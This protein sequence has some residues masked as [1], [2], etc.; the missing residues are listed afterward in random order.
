ML[1]AIPSLFATAFVS[2]A[3]VAVL[4]LG[5]VNAERPTST[6]PFLASDELNI[7]SGDTA[8]SATGATTVAIDIPTRQM[9]GWGGTN[10]G[11]SGETAFQS[12][13]I[14]NGAWISAERVRY[15]AGN[16]K[17]LV[18]SGNDV[19]AAKDLG[20]T[21]ETYT[22]ATGATAQ[23][24]LDSFVKPKIQAGSPVVLGFYQLQEF[25]DASFD[26]SLII[27]GVELDS[28]G[29]VVGIYFNDFY[30]SEVRYLGKFSEIDFSENDQFIADREGCRTTIA[31]SQPYDYC[32]PSGTQRAIAL[33]GLDMTN[34]AGVYTRLVDR[35]FLEPDWGKEDNISEVP[36]DTKFT[37]VING[38]LKTNQNYTVLR[39]DSFQSTCASWS[40][41]FVYEGV[42]NGTETLTN[43]TTL[44][45][46]GKYY[47]V[48]VPTG[49]DFYT[50]AQCGAEAVMTHLPRVALLVI[51]LMFLYF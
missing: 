6:I 42:E 1:R 29:G 44:K 8:I 38:N 40:Y 36:V 41:E 37:L 24:F 50:R 12:A 32:I 35:L 39:F 7:R 31:L 18:G 13:L 25:G 49:S 19:T 34:S 26:R 30:T 45:S 43:V 23:N 22:P 9:W 15:A 47:F 51:S 2:L 27:T 20:L 5:L 14:L 46:D 16:T 33:T 17:L 3:L 4:L 21:Y 11:Y 48:T 28:S 10:K